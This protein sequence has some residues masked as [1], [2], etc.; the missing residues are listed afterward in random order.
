MFKLLYVYMVRCADD[1]YYV[2]VTNDINRRL[3]EHNEGVNKRAYTFLR[4]PVKL[5]YWQ[6]FTDYNQAMGWETQL[7]KW[8][9]KK[10]EALIDKDWDKIKE[11]AISYS[12]RIK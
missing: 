8:G 11:L 6:E 9:R 7:K 5:V 12:K 1:S 2:G 10:K 3:G 4:R